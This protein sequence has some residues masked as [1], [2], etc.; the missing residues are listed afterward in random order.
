MLSVQ[1]RNR[2]KADVAVLNWGTPFEEA[3]L[4]PF[5]EVQRDGHP[6]AYGGATVKRGDPD[7]S[8]YVR[9]AA[10]GHRSAALDLAEVFDFSE[11][12]RYTVH[13]RIRLYDVVNAPAGVPRVLAQHTAVSLECGPPLVIQVR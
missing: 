4:Q 1:L 5:V 8:E 12:G 7:A 2:G 6:L 9:I 13:T 3:W 11:H 10:N